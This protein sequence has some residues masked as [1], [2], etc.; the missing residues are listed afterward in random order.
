[1]D[2]DGSKRR[3]TADSI[4]GDFDALYAAHYS[5]LVVILHAFIGD[6]GEAQD[7]AQEAF[8]RAWQRWGVI[9]SYENP[10][11]W[12]RRVGI[13]LATSRFR[14][15]R[16]A[17][18]HLRRERPRVVPPLLPDHVALVAALRRIPT[19]QRTALVLH[20]LVDLSIADISQELGVPVGT[21]K[22]WL[23]RGRNALAAQLGDADTAGRTTSREATR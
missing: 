7:L 20:Y 17:D 2:A 5:E 21:V 9:A 19:N 3:R 12:L 4:A 23:S 1:M 8:C 14:R 18:R 11:A 13:N 10:A 22:A 15:L 6:L 16:V